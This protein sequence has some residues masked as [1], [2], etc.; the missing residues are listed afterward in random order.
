MWQRKNWMKNDNK[1]NKCKSNDVAS[2]HSF[3]PNKHR[4]PEQKKNHWTRTVDTEEA[5]TANNNILSFVMI[6]CLIL[7]FFP[8]YFH[9]WHFKCRVTPVA[10]PNLLS[11]FHWIEASFRQQQNIV[12]IIIFLTGLLYLMQLM[13]GAWC[14]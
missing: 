4:H 12:S 13:K 14:L 7:I 9:R 3:T 8:F 6:V 10:R 11:C 5:T 2:Q 1:N